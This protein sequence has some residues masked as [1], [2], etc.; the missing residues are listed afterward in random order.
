MMIATSKAVTASM[1]GKLHKKVAF[2]TF[3]EYGAFKKS[4]RVGKVDL[5]T[6]RYTLLKESEVDQ[7]FVWDDHGQRMLSYPSKFQ[8]AGWQRSEQSLLRR[9]NS[10]T[11]ST[12]W[13]SVQPKV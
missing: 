12:V 8:G 11:N 10:V 9:K 3:F 4:V 13:E 7:H 6:V 5:D 2:Y 1:H